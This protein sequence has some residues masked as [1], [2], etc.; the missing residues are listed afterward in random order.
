M[1]AND[2]VIRV[3]VC[4]A[5]PLIHLD[6]LGSLSLLSDFG[7]ILVPIAV[8]DEVARHRPQALIVGGVPLRRVESL[9]MASADL[10][11][12]AR[13]LPLHDGEREAL[14]LAQEFRAEIL[15]SDDTAARLAAGALGIAVHG[16]IGIL[17]RG[18]RRGSLTGSEVAALLR[19][20][21]TVSTLHVKRALLDEFTRRAEEWPA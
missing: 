7:E 17:F 21:P 13:T 14:K 8:W 12:L 4:D 16:T 5:G 1:A 6:E 9:S 20:I 15:L 11:A 18:I 3:V 10:D 2:A 19:S